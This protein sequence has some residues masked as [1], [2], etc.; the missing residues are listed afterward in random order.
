MNKYIL[1][2]IHGWSVYLLSNDYLCIYLGSIIIEICTL[3]YY[4]KKKLS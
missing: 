2:N 1:P 3:L 4:K